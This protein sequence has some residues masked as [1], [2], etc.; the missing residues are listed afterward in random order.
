MEEVRHSYHM[1][2]FITKQEKYITDINDNKGQTTIKNEMPGGTNLKDDHLKVWKIK[3][4]DSL[5]QLEN[6][7]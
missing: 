2:E 3:M 4:I 5:D 6:F 1:Y 7:I